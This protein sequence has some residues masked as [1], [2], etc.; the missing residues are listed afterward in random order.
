MFSLGVSDIFYDFS[1]YDVEERLGTEALVINGVATTTGSPARISGAF[2][3]TLSIVADG[4]KFPRSY[5]AECKSNAHALEMM[6]R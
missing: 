1:V 3:G 5:L 6:R 4:G 2:A